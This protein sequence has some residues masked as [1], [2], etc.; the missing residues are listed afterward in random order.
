MYD[1]LKAEK[2]ILN[3]GIQS[4]TVSYW[5]QILPELGESASCRLKKQGHLDLHL[6]VMDGAFVPSI[7]FGMP[8]IKS[9][10]QVTNHDC[11]MFI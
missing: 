3:Y 4:S 7:S 10:R 1:E 6:D 11:L 9:L 5:R 2:E 8:V